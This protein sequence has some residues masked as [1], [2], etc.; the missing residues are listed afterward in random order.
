MLIG[1]LV[2]VPPLP[3]VAVTPLPLKPTAVAPFRFAP[4]MVAG[5]LVPAAPEDGLIPV[6][7]GAGLA[8]TVK[9]LNGAEVPAG[10]VAVTLRGPGG[11]LA[12]IVTV[13]GR[14]DAVPPLPIVAV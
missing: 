9:L 13:M 5:R 14:L 7:T 3:I 4:L 1:R 6:I 12:A 8:V 11:A 2:A 10:V